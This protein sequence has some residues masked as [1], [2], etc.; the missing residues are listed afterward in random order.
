MSKNNKFKIIFINDE[1][2][3]GF[4]C[5]LLHFFDIGIKKESARNPCAFSYKEKNQ[6]FRDAYSLGREMFPLNT[7]FTKNVK[8]K[9]FS[10]MRSEW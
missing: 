7:G 8:E 9:D 5:I 10:L 2:Y 6:N 4:L 3:R 1:T